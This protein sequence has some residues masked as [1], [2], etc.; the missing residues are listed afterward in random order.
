MQKIGY[1][2]RLSRVLEQRAEENRRKEKRSLRI[3]GGAAVALCGA[4][5]CF[6][7][8][9]AATLAYFGTARFEAM[10]V[11]SSDRSASMQL[12]LTGIDPVTRVLAEAMSPGVTGQRGG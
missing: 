3:A 9:K 6:F 8:L 12:W 7:L 5:A 4:V 10:N 2:T 1:M 11:A